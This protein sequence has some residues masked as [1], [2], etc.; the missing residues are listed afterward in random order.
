MNKAL[1]VLFL[2]SSLVFA[3]QAANKQVLV[4]E[5]IKNIK[6]VRKLDSTILQDISDP[7]YY[8]KTSNGV[9][10]NIGTKPNTTTI[11][12]ANKIQ[13]IV[14]S[15]VKIN[16]IWFKQND[17]IDNQIIKSVLKDGIILENDLGEQS[18]ET[19]KKEYNNEISIK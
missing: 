1:F 7:F 8:G 9:L 16:D 17:K 19:V 12:T 2:F 15:R 18:I 14:G 11:N 3:Q 4:N 6:E 5:D 13:A 10:A